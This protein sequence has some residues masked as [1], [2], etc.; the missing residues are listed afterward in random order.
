MSRN[1][2]EQAADMMCCALCGTAQVDDIKLKTCTACKSVRYCS[3]KCQKEHRSQH[4]R[5]CKKRAAELHD[6]ILFKQPES[7]YEG[8]CP[9]CFLPRSLDQKKST[10]MSCCSKIICNGCVYSNDSR[11]YQEK[12]VYACPFCRHLDP[13]TKD[14]EI[15]NIM[16]RVNANDPAALLQMGLRRYEDGDNDSAFK[17]VK[18]S[19]ELGDAGA[20]YQLAC[21]YFEGKGVQKDVKKE[22]YHL[23]QAAIGGHA[24]ARWNLGAVEKKNCRMGRAI[25]HMII[26]A[27]LGH[28]D[29]LDALRN[30]FRGGLVSKEDFASALRAHQAAVEATKSS[31]REA[32]EEAEKV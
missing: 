21:F 7:S 23:E 10:M 30:G 22:V 26:A 14:E 12:L 16:K 28:D 15:K 8:D 13:K 5:A 19:A 24:K 9:I 20:H 11:I 2:E 18:K 17:F 4:K 27:K 29:S 3:I 1:S 32:A 6:E 25:K 31:Q